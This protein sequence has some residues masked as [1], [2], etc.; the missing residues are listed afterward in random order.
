MHRLLRVDASGVAEID[1]AALDVAALRA[2]GAGFVWLDVVN[3]PGD[4][5]ALDLLEKGFGFHPIAIEDCVLPQYHSRVEKYADHVFFSVQG[6][7][8]RPGR[9]VAKG[10][11]SD[12]VYELDT[13]IGARYLVTVHE[14][15]LPALD[16]VWE[17]AKMKAAVYAGAPEHLLHDVF[18]AVTAS[19]NPLV[20]EIELKVDDVQADMLKNVERIR[21]N[22]IV[23]LKR[24][25]LEIRRVLEPQL[26][27][28][29]A[30]VTE[31]QDVA[32][33]RVGAYLRN[34]RFQL[35][36]LDRLT[37]LYSQILTSSLE[38]Y[39]A[40][41][42]ARLNT[43]MKYL[44]VLGTLSMPPLF[45][46]SYYGMN[47]PFPEQRLGPWAL[48]LVVAVMGLLTVGFVAFLKRRGLL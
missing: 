43:T 1:A 22:D 45:V 36:R 3:L 7:S 44:A 28:F 2:G 12:A 6:V 5:R 20:A 19:F 39:Y 33:R 26:V 41:L 14:R 4:D 27:A 8:G 15:E 37:E 32:P 17:R 9:L 35:E 16:R 46:V 13:F 47:V 25:L 11:V 42:S 48:P 23:A 30:L 34:T 40:S 29:A 24:R 10:G 31:L 38:V 21:V 18:A